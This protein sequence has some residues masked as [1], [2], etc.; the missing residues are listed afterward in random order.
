[1]KFDLCIGGGEI[2]W[3]FIE[4][5]D[6]DKVWEELIASYGWQLEWAEKRGDGTGARSHIVIHADKIPTSYRWKC[7]F[8]R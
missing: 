6:R 3:E 4:G 2:F 1:M 5:A 8:L 7:T